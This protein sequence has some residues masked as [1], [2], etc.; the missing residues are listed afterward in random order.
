VYTIEMAARHGA[1]RILTKIG[2]NSYLLQG[3]S[4]YSRGAVGMIDLEGGPAIW[5]DAFMSEI[6][7]HKRMF[8]KGEKIKDFKSITKQQAIDSRA[9]LD[10]EIKDSVYIIISTEK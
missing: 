9:V 3:E 4:R 10:G 5:K 7:G 8:A 1:P 6:F 2:D